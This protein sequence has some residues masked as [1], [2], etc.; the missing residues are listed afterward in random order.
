MSLD[1]PVLIFD[2]ICVLFSFLLKFVLWAD[3][4]KQRLQCATVQSEMGRAEFIKRNLDP[5]KYKGRI[6]Q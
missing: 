5:E 1:K 3:A 4:K 2:G 6:V